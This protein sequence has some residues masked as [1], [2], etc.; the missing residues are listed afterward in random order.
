MAQVK[1]IIVGTGGMARAHLSNMLKMPRTTKLVGFVETGE[2]SRRDTAA[3]FTAAGLECPPFYNTIKEL[4]KA[5]GSP[6]AAFIVTP[7]KYHLENTRDCLKAGMDVLLEKPMVLNVAEAKQLIKLRDQTGRLVVVAFPGSLSPAIW[8]AKKLIAKGA[9]GRV[10]AVSALAY[11]SWKQFTVGTWRQDPEISGGGFLFDTGSHMVNTVVELLGEDVAK[12]SALMDNRGTPVEIASSVSGVSKS[13][14]F[15]SLTGAGD[16]I[17]CNSEITVFGDKAV[18]KT[19]IWGENLSLKKSGENEFKP[20]KYAASSGPWEQFLR[21]RAGKLE[22][23]CP[24][25]IGL[26]FAKLMDMIRQSAVESRT[27]SAK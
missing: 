12:V 20:V 21:V 11:Q 14:V 5:Q 23:P 7:H 9:L 17:N 27:V 8:E 4:V 18:L 15:F 13:G 19:G 25:E 26:R 3:M 2:A 10:T 16:S 6:D 24:P 22:N 1:T